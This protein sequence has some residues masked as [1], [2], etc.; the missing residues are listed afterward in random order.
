[1]ELARTWEVQREKQT[2]NCRCG[3]LAQLRKKAKVSDLGEV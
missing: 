2:L 1:M 3:K